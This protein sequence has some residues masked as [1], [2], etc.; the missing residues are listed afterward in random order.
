MGI[1]SLEP[2]RIRPSINAGYV[3]TADG[4]ADFDDLYGKA[5]RALKMASSKGKGICMRY[6]QKITDWSESRPGA[7]A[8]TGVERRLQLS[9]A[10]HF[11]YR[12]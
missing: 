3:M 11:C 12:P 9:A 7:G 1:L 10:L 8:L 5:E 4:G 6:G 2:A